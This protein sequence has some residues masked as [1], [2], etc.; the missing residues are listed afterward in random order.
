MVLL[1]HRWRRLVGMT[2]SKKKEPIT[3]RKRSPIDYVRLNGDNEDDTEPSL[4]S[5]K[6]SRSKTRKSEVSSPSHKECTFHSPLQN[7]YPDGQRI[8][9]YAGGQRYSSSPEGQQIPVYSEAQSI[10]SYPE[11]L[12]ISSSPVIINR[13]SPSSS[14][15]DDSSVSSVST[16]PSYT[17]AQP[18]MIPPTAPVTVPRTPYV[19]SNVM[20][21]PYVPMWPATYP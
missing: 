15:S 17:F 12:P 19:Y 8:T 16:L 20:Y 18:V 2:F 5:H 4:S 1:L 13:T 9:S 14:F 3:L 7:L 21:I 10:P 6:H 11:G